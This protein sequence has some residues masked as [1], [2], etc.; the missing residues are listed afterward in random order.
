MSTSSQTK[1]F[2]ILEMRWNN[3]FNKFRTGTPSGC[4]LCLAGY[5]WDPS[6][7]LLPMLLLRVHMGNLFPRMLPSNRSCLSWALSRSSAPCIHMV[8]WGQRQMVA[9]YHLKVDQVRLY[10]TGAILEFLWDFG[11]RWGRWRGKRWGC[12]NQPLGFFP[13]QHLC[14]LPVLISCLV[15]SFILQTAPCPGQRL[16][17]QEPLVSAVSRKPHP[18]K[19]LANLL[20]RHPSHGIKYGTGHIVRTLGEMLCLD[21]VSP[22]LNALRIQFSHS[23]TDLERSYDCMAFNSVN[24]DFR[25][26]KFQAIE[27][28]RHLLSWLKQV[29][30]QV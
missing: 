6:F 21:L 5:C 29:Q 25:W 18:G 12:D 20:Q 17:A 1:W 3:L 27:M 8:P 22:L 16:R 28:G 9:A 10:H 15:H 24:I 14:F 4:S 7:D 19:G 2:R 23:T 26:E 13:Q 30:L 11:E